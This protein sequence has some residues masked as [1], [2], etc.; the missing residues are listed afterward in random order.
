MESETL[1]SNFNI[2]K[3]ENIKNIKEIESL[4][5]KVEEIYFTN[6]KPERNE[7]LKSSI[8]NLI[9]LINENLQISN[10]LSKEEISFLYSVKSFALDK[11]PEYSKESEESATKSVKNIIIYINLNYLK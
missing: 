5:G 7:L 11:F 3:M 8:L 4:F 6:Y 10:S 9:Q 2:E 1:S